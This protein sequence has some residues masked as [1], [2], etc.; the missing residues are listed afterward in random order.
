MEDPLGELPADGG[1]E[2]NDL[3]DFASAHNKQLHAALRAMEHEVVQLDAEFRDATERTRTMREHLANVQA[4]AGTTQQLVDARSHEIATEDHLKQLAE[5]ERGRFV[6]ELR[7]HAAEVS[8]L[9]EQLGLAQGAA[10]K[11]TERMDAFKLRMNWSQEELEQWAL[12]ARQKE[13]DALALARYAKAD[14]ARIRELNL[15]IEKM[16]AAAGAKRAELEAEVTDTQAQQIVL[17]KTA[18]DFRALHAERQALVRRWEEAVGA[19]Q[20]RDRDIEAATER[21]RSGKAALAGTQA[22]HAEREA[23]L[24]AQLAQNEA[25]DAQIGADERELAAV[26]R[27]Q[28]ESSAGFGELTDQLELMRATLAKAAAELARARGETASLAALLDERKGGL[29]R[30]R[31]GLQRA[32]ADLT[33]HAARALSLEQV[34]AARRRAS[35]TRHRAL[36]DSH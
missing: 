36:T 16:M 1:Q 27:V 20:R 9:R 26:R 5:R 34:R 23:A 32:E 13:E 17:D 35:P 2:F 15:Q 8:E 29:E 22:A 28:A 12:A 14:E 7:K 11:A 19:M 18:E 10:L 30:K 6:A 3:P 24:A 21:F 33:E 4:E 25:L 31:R